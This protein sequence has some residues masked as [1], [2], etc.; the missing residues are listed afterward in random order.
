MKLINLFLL[1]L[2]LS[3]STT[4][5]FCAAEHEI[6][7][8][9]E[10]TP[11]VA[12]EAK[13]AY[14]EIPLEQA[15]ERDDAAQVVKLLKPLLAQLPPGHVRQGLLNALLNTAYQANKQ[16][17]TI[18]L[19]QH[20]A[21]PGLI[22]K[23]TK[24]RTMLMEMV[25]DTRIFNALINNGANPF[26]YD[27]DGYSALHYCVRAQNTQAGLSSARQLIAR[28]GVDYGNRD[29]K[30]SLLAYAAIRTDRCALIALALD[31]HADPENDQ[32]CTRDYTIK[33]P[34]THALTET[35]SQ[36]PKKYALECPFKTALLL[37]T[38]GSTTQHCKLSDFFSRAQ[39]AFMKRERARRVADC[40]FLK[41][42]FPPEQLSTQPFSQN[43]NAA[44]KLLLCTALQQQLALPITALGKTPNTTRPNTTPLDLI[45]D[46]AAY[47]P[48]GDNYSRNPALPVPTR[49]C[50]YQSCSIQ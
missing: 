33:K 39:I 47:D 31:S 42:L 41:N 13:N 20:G 14:Q 43:Y 24:G 18:A 2:T 19:V 22:V 7:I 11:E 23:K 12:H 3:L 15:I 45:G 50:D 6:E 49:S 5:A 17:T 37:Y 36:E 30:Q 48:V 46:Y 8:A 16:H 1:C 38:Y 35:L 28:V 26:R 21:S 40:A 44:Q 27:S 25:G 29:T 32:A 9:Q 4:P 10:T 34:L